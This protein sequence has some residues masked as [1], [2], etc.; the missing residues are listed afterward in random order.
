MGIGAGVA[1]RVWSSVSGAGAG[2]QLAAATEVVGSAADRVEGVG[3][4]NGSRQSLCS[5]TRPHHRLQGT[6]ELM[7]MANLG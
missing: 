3:R 6:A 2:S 7:S 4:V 1:L 5:M